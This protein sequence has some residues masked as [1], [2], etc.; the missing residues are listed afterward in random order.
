VLLWKRF[1]GKD[2]FMFEM[3]EIVVALMLAIVA[4]I[5][6]WLASLSAVIASREN[7]RKSAPVWRAF[8][9]KSDA[10]E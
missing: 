9:R 8:V 4:V 3:S 2:V 1:F 7:Q 5:A 10:R 6:C